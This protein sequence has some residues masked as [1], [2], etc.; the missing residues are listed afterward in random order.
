[1]ILIALPAFGQVSDPAS[2]RAYIQANDSLWASVVAAKQSAFNKNTNDPALRWDLALA[3]YG[4]LNATMRTHDENRFDQ[5]YEKAEDHL[6]TLGKDGEY[7]ADAK[8]LLGGLYGLKLSYS[9]M[10]GMVLG[11]RSSGLIE[12][13]IE[14]DPKSPI[15][16]RVEANSKM[17]TPSM[18]GGNIDEAVQA[19]ERSIALFEEQPAT[20]DNNWI[21]LDALVFAGQAYTKQGQTAKAIAVYEKVLKIEPNHSWV[22]SDLLPKARQKASGK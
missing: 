2:Y 18:F 6:K 11:P 16:W 5:Y 9:S 22:K 21:Y 17:Y 12:D 7:K 3:Q 15:V 14:L 19:F 4:L 20:L 13:A 8:A 1:M 10:M